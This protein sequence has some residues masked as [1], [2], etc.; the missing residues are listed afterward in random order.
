MR[1]SNSC[2][3]VGPKK[4]RTS[5]WVA[6]LDGHGKV[7]YKHSALGNGQAGYVGCEHG[8]SMDLIA[9]TPTIHPVTRVGHYIVRGMNKKINVNSPLVYVQI[10]VQKTNL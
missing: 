10:I 5:K 2:C 3:A 4:S 6:S 9:L 1:S 8:T 7:V